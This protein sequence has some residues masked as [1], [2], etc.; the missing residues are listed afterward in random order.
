MNT[1]VIYTMTTGGEMPVITPEFESPLTY[2][3]VEHPLMGTPM[4]NSPGS[5]D[6][7]III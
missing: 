2:R 1:S 5:D 7:I 6:I 4:K 3:E